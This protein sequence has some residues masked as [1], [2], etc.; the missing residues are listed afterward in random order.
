ERLARRTHG[1]DDEVVDLAL[2]LRLHPLVGIEAAVGAVAARDLTG[3]FGRQI[4]DVEALDP[5]CA[6]FALEQALP[7]RLDAAGERRHHADPRNDD[8]PHHKLPDLAAKII[9]PRRLHAPR[10]CPILAT[11]RVPRKPPAGQVLS[12]LLT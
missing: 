2:L 8:T 7:A 5:A 3:D 6:A 9:I 11:G 10:Q 1:K 12:L 4:G